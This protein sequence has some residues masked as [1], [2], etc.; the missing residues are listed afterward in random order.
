MAVTRFY[1]Q[2]A[3]AVGQWLTLRR[4]DAKPRG[5]Y[6]LQWGFVIAFICILTFKPF[7]LRSLIQCP[8]E[9]NYNPETWPVVPCSSH[10]HRSQRY[11]AMQAIDGEPCICIECRSQDNGTRVMQWSCCEHFIYIVLFCSFK[12]KVNIF[13][14]QFMYNVPNVR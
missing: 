9:F 4:A 3:S 14:C 8:D 10:V 12:S 11:N 2:S 6:E 5:L 7:S 13:K 1:R